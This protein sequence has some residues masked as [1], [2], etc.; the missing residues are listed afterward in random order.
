VQQESVCLACCFYFFVTIRA[1]RRITIS[2]IP[3]YTYGVIFFEVAGAGVDTGAAAAGVDTGCT[4][5][6][7]EYT[8]WSA[9][10]TGNPSLLT[11]TSLFFRLLR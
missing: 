8:I 3:A 11:K 6:G 7:A 1:I 5:G 10:W 4:T 2:P 9:G